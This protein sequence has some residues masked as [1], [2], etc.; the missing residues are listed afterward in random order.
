MS[1]A[2]KLPE[3]FEGFMQD[4]EVGCRAA[5]DNVERADVFKRSYAWALGWDRRQVKFSLVQKRLI[6]IAEASGLLDIGMPAFNDLCEVAQID[7]SALRRVSTKSA[8][9]PLPLI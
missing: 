4:I 6:D 1:A 2:E 3:P 9:A 5:N 8:S 7:A